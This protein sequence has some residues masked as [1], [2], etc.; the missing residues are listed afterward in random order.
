MEDD[1]EE[2]SLKE[3]YYQFMD[4]LED[5]NVKS[6]EYFVN[7]L[8]D[9]NIPSFPVF[10]TICLLFFAGIGLGLY[11]LLAGAS[12]STYPFTVSFN[13]S[14]EYTGTVTII[15][16]GQSYS[17]AVAS[18]KAVFT[19]LPDGV[20]DISAKIDGETSD[21]RASS[22]PI[23]TKEYQF[24][25]GSL[26]FTGEQATLQV[27]ISDSQ[28][29][30]L[31]QGARVSAWSS[32]NPSP[33]VKNTSQS[34][35]VSFTFNKGDVV[36]VSV[37]ASGYQSSV[38]SVVLT[39]TQNTLE[40]A[41]NQ[42][43]SCIGTGCDTQDQKVDVR[44]Q[45][46]D[47][48]GNDLPLEYARVRLMYSD[49]TGQHA[50]TVDS[51]NVEKTTDAA[52]T[53]YF[54]KMSIVGRD[55]FI[56]VLPPDG[57]G[58]ALYNGV[59]DVQT[60]TTSS[61]VL[62][63]F[64]KLS[65]SS[66]RADCKNDPTLPK[67]KNQIFTDGKIKLTVVD[68]KDN[69][70]ISGASVNLYFSGGV[71][72]VP[73]QDKTT[74]F[75]GYVDWDVASGTYYV[76]VVK[77][78]YL[79]GFLLNLVD[80]SD[81]TLGL[82]K[83]LIGNSQQ[84]QVL[85]VDDDDNPVQSA[86]VSLYYAGTTASGI[87]TGLIGTTGTDGFAYFDNMPI[88]N[89]QYKADA[90]IGSR[91]GE[92]IFKMDFANPKQVIVKVEPQQVPFSVIIKDSITRSVIQGA[93]VSIMQKQSVSNT[94]DANGDAEFL[95]DSQ[96][97][98]TLNVT[99][100]NYLDYF[101]LS[102]FTLQP[103]KK[104]SRTIYLT[105]STFK[106]DLKASVTISQ[107]SVPGVDTATLIR[108]QYYNLKLSLSTPS[109]GDY[110]L[111][112]VKIGDAQTAS[113]EEVVITQPDSTLQN[114]ASPNT[115]LQNLR[116]VT[117][118][119]LPPCDV[120]GA[121]DEFKWVM[122]N[123]TPSIASTTLNPSVI[124]VKPTGT[125]KKIRVYYGAVIARG[126]QSA[127]YEQQDVSNK[128]DSIKNVC[129]AS[130]S[131]KDYSLQQQD[132]MCN[133]KAC[134][135]ATF[136]GFNGKQNQ[137]I[138]GQQ[139]ILN[140]KSTEFQELKS[141]QL[142]I[143]DE[144]GN[145]VFNSYDLTDASGGPTNFNPSD[146]PVLQDV[147]MTPNLPDANALPAISALLDLTLTP[148]NKA[149]STI[150]TVQLLDNG[151]VILQ[152][153]L[154]IKLNG[155]QQMQATLV[156]I[157]SPS[158]QPGNTINVNEPSYLTFQ[159]TRTIAD[160]QG[161]FQPIT[162]AFAQPQNKDQANQPFGLN[163][164]AGLQGDGSTNKGED[165]LYK[166]LVTPILP[167]LMNVQFTQKA[168]IPL[169][170]IDINV[171][172]SQYLQVDPSEDVGLSLTGDTCTKQGA[173]KIRVYNT[174]AASVTVNLQPDQTD[175]LAF[176]AP[177]L[178][179]NP[180][181]SICTFTMSKG[182]FAKPSVK[183]I[184]VYAGTNPVA[185][186]IAEITSNIGAAGQSGQ[187]ILNLPVQLNCPIIYPNVT[188]SP[189]AKL[190]VT[191]DDC[192]PYASTGTCE[193][194]ACLYN[195]AGQANQ[196]G[197][198]PF[199]GSQPNYCTAN[200]ICNVGMC[201]C[202][203]IISNKYL[204]GFSDK[205]LTY[206]LMNE[207]QSTNEPRLANPA[208]SPY[209]AIS[210]Y[211]MQ[212]SGVSDVSL[213]VDPL[214]QSDGFA[215]TFDNQASRSMTLST[216]I[217]GPNS[218]CLVFN[219]DIA[220][221]DKSIISYLYIRNLF[222]LLSSSSSFSTSGIT[223]PSGK[224]KTFTVL[225]D[226]RKVG[227]DY[228]SIKEST[229][230]LSFS[231]LSSGT[232]KASINVKIKK[233]DSTELNNLKKIQIPLKDSAIPRRFTNAQETMLTVDNSKELNNKFAYEET[234]KEKGF[235]FN[236]PKENSIVKGDLL[237]SLT[238][239]NKDSVQDC[240]KNDYCLSKPTF[241]EYS[242][243]AKTVFNSKNPSTILRTS[244]SQGKKLL[245]SAVAALYD[246][247]NELCTDVNALYCLFNVTPSLSNSNQNQYNYY[248]NLQDPMLSGYYGQ[249]GSGYVGFPQNPMGSGGGYGG[250]YGN[251]G[252]P[253]GFQ[254]FGQQDPLFGYS[255]CNFQQVLNLVCD[256]LRSPT[257][258]RSTGASKVLSILGGSFVTSLCRAN[259]LSLVYDARQLRRVTPGQYGA[260]GGP[261]PGILGS[262]YD[263]NSF[264][265]GFSSAD[266]RLFDSAASSRAFNAKVDAHVPYKFAG[267]VG[268]LR[269]S[270]L[271]FSFGD[272][273]EFKVTKD[274]PLSDY[275][276]TITSKTTQ[277]FVGYPYLTCTTASCQVKYDEYKPTLYSFAKYK[278]KTFGIV[279]KD[280]NGFDPADYLTP[281][282]GKEVNLYACDIVKIDPLTGMPVY[283]DTENCVLPASIN[284]KYAGY[285]KEGSAFLGVHVIGNNVYFITNKVISKNLEEFYINN[286]K[287]VYEYLTRDSNNSLTLNCT[288]VK[289]SDDNNLIL[290]C[291]ATDILSKDVINI[292]AYVYNESNTETDDVLSLTSPN[293]YDSNK[294]F[295]KFWIGY[296]AADDFFDD[297]PFTNV[298][299]NQLTLEKGNGV[300]SGFASGAVVI[301]NEGYL[302]L[303]PN[304]V[305]QS[306]TLTLNSLG[307]TLTTTIQFVKQSGVQTPSVS[308]SP[309][310]EI[311]VSP[312]PNPPETKPPVS[313]ELDQ[314]K[315]KKCIYK[316][317]KAAGYPAG[318]IRWIQITDSEA[319]LE[320]YTKAV[321]PGKGVTKKERKK[322]LA[323]YN[324]KR[325]ATKKQLAN[326]DSSQRVPVEI[327]PTVSPKGYY[328]I[329]LQGSDG[330]YHR[331]DY[332]GSSFV[333]PKSN[334]GQRIVA[335][336]RDPKTKEC[337]AARYWDNITKIKTVK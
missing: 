92:T 201:N 299:A 117:F 272:V 221:S 167:G 262:G 202:R 67:C 265:S 325:A 191:D 328:E 45:L 207:F 98:S 287:M 15:I 85:V 21:F 128:Y 54:E 160:E 258:F 181:N 127:L 70:T 136:N 25:V 100:N 168:F 264:S 157:D 132:S 322:L 327:D 7:P 304:G 97:P 36:Q 310:P 39:K 236:D 185:N 169:T 305:E 332:D 134:L 309:S 259:I 24:Q 274:S 284:T 253:S 26:A 33:T 164:P 307:K 16:N 301:D 47:V 234:T 188:I 69:S 212:N 303:I 84:L 252:Y 318:D 297:I 12:V 230:S 336:I 143:T 189:F 196:V 147:K 269:V 144:S 319:T 165:G 86:Q 218:D 235:T 206:Y 96:V 78:G 251:Y 306:I 162:N 292:S 290:G 180:T 296:D 216:Q 27:R 295:Y 158:A 46:Q 255:G 316:V 260:Y 116:K 222:D 105:P 254:G 103:G 20:A 187:A 159:L 174:L 171:F 88:D 278:V 329:Y 246:T 77:D 279:P 79:P 333:V 227:C 118:G 314:D 331:A 204:E 213:S 302:L 94:T 99:A 14:S 80:G 294:P 120:G 268:G 1:V 266:R 334:D 243:A 311:T 2:G 300:F 197:G 211:G 186:C 139:Y 63:F 195:P 250:N 220:S 238:D 123:Y 286:T 326:W 104:T 126:K 183:S 83:A 55:V 125:Q 293:V 276:S 107:S 289:E 270:T 178:N 131:Y 214:S 29:S 22:I 152:K 76:T 245:E 50:V 17:Q 148:K 4:W 23:N 32:A 232:Q 154:L 237:G 288:T 95:L 217:T 335:A 324:K 114:P 48:N 313:D 18:S 81:K 49:L 130:L 241:N 65:N 28:S 161:V 312:S 337:V 60:A 155:N 194:Q 19:N 93:T 121:V 30:K 58:Y 315:L 233:L 82:Q 91:S 203:D 153:K 317:N 53:V 321:H 219:E 240:Q 282:E 62:E 44:V 242:S 228:D 330:I 8:E 137:A 119:E 124:Y 110:V 226:P 9:N 267:D 151:N 41:L 208:N 277:K 205:F 248:G 141:P 271:T 59:S 273:N 38:A 150:L 57:S 179:C 6:Y 198:C 323:E 145:L 142:K 283:S 193:K 89:N 320:E 182:T 101:D 308:V 190:C 31:I 231:S 66:N 102:S 163:S 146:T 112:F 280:Y 175:C 210:D 35:I 239:N 156:K 72:A 184:N 225:Y 140:V 229:V 247:A 291:D 11:Y 64:P 166:I 43:V 200:G 68:A 52:G 40:V 285:L 87:A 176:S 34:G 51:Q 223:I 56:A 261:I 13:G 115:G 10:I 122:V 90:I 133:D 135:Y 192:G 138:V 73:F 199:Y 106:D 61:S 257:R 170:S 113:D 129:L 281:K 256:S 3:K 173:Q 108:G 111:G 74:D 5:H 209:I 177:G 275:T 298:K 37:S 109:N 172:A 224:P 263:V 71:S 244:Y 75:N 42:K 149:S 249:G 215:I